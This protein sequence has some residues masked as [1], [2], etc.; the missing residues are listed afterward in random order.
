MVL[1]RDPSSAEASI[2]ALGRGCTRV[3]EH[4]LIVSDGS[5]EFRCPALTRCQGAVKLLAG[6]GEKLVRSAAFGST[7]RQPSDI[8]L[9]AIWGRVVLTTSDDQSLVEPYTRLF[10]CDIKVASRRTAFGKVRRRLYD[11]RHSR[12]RPCRRLVQTAIDS[13]CENGEDRKL[14]YDDSAHHRDNGPSRHSR[15]PADWAATDKSGL[16]SNEQAEDKGTGNHGKRRPTGRCGE[17]KADDECSRRTV[18]QY[19]YASG[20]ARFEG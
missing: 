1:H 10:D 14:A 12:S 15:P 9:R 11:R 18:E 3:T 6:I 16:H 8:S 5:V 2:G 17:R 20:A 19:D 7:A 4:P 13:S